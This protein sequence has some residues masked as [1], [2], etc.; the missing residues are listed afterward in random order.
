MMRNLTTIFITICILSFQTVMA[1]PSPRVRHYDH[2][3]G[4]INEYVYDLRQ[5]SLG[6]LW[7]STHGGLYSFDGNRFVC[8][9]DSVVALQ[10]GY[11]WEA[12]TDMETY[13][14]QLILNRPDAPPHEKIRCSLTDRDGHLWV[15]STSGLWLFEDEGYPASHISLDQEV[16]CLFRSSS[17]QLWMTARNGMVCLLDSSLIPTAWLTPDGMWSSQPALFGSVVS[18]ITEDESNGLWFSARYSG[19]IH[20]TRHSAELRDGYDVTVYKNEGGTDSLCTL[21][22]V[23]A[24]DI[25]RF[26]RLW[27][28]SLKSGVSMIR[29]AQHHTFVI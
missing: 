12:Q 1:V 8:H 14:A 18:H 13:A 15:G 24:T 11:H 3:N 29:S 19:L 21:V 28:L 26:G 10:P 7:L 17:G 20:L 22:N 2:S 6:L 27:A 5:D 9:P 25:D 23:Y 4:G 16:L